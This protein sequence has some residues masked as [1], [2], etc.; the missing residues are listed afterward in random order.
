MIT[1]SGSLDTAMLHWFFNQSI[2]QDKG[3]KSPPSLAAKL[4]R[5]SK[6]RKDNPDQEERKRERN[7]KK[8]SNSNSNSLVSSQNFLQVFNH[9][10]LLLLFWNATFHSPTPGRTPSQHNSSHSTI[11]SSPLFNAAT[12]STTHIV[13]RPRIP[14]P[15]MLFILFYS[16]FTIPS[17]PMLLKPYYSIL[18][19][20]NH[21][22]FKDYKCLLAIPATNSTNHNC[23]PLEQAPL[24]NSD[25]TQTTKLSS[26]RTRTHVACQPPTAASSIVSPPHT[27]AGSRSTSYKERER[28]RERGTEMQTRGQKWR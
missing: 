5:N 1:S 23:S 7:E 17:P 18:G 25:K 10:Q 20:K 27:P 2:L 12:N 8:N 19:R 14:S 15:P 4:D 3:K 21:L 13:H 11:A 9:R 16:I 6:R 26:S 24:T 28:E 22:F